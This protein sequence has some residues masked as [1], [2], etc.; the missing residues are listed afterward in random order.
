M[1]L[2]GKEMKN[3]NENKR[4]ILLLLKW[5]F[6]CFLRWFDIF[7]FIKMF[8]F[9]HLLKG[10]SSEIILTLYVCYFFSFLKEILDIVVLHE[11]GGYIVYN[12]SV[13]L[14][15]IV[16]VL[17]IRLCL[18]VTRSGRP[19]LRCFRFRFRFWGVKLLI[20]GVMYYESSK[21]LL[22]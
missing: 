4:N 11:W 9:L 20:I 14:L 1:F 5:K 13:S 6:L 21:L 18:W 8:L 2:L 17:D 7:L 10:K 19:V 3:K 15:C 16:Q 22:G 12:Y